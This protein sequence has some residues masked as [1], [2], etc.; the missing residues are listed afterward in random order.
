M[1]ADSIECQ[2]IEKLCRM[3]PEEAARQVGTKLLL[4]VTPH[5]I[6]YERTKVNERGWEHIRQ[7]IR[8]NG[9]GIVGSSLILA[10]ANTGLEL[11]MGLLLDKGADIDTRSEYGRQ[12]SLEIAAMQGHEAVVRFLLI[13]G[14]N[15][16]ATNSGGNTALILATSLGHEAIVRLLVE[17]GAN[18]NLKNDNGDVAIDYATKFP[19][20]KNLLAAAAKNQPDRQ[21]GVSYSK[22]ERP[23][24]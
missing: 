16:D 17:N 23:R 14:F 10:I 2:E 12:T 22:R 8:N 21:E 18:I 11:P 6:Y 24:K 19:A 3:A 5:T 15:V 9:K 20:I 1:Y 4:S 7:S 13:K